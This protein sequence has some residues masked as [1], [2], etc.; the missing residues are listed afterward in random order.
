MQV[1]KLAWPSLTTNWVLIYCKI[2]RITLWAFDLRLG[3][4]VSRNFQPRR[5]SLRLV[6]PMRLSNYQA[7]GLYRVVGLSIVQIPSLTMYRLVN[8]SRAP[9]DL[10]LS[11]ARDH[12]E[13]L[14]TY[15]VHGSHEKLNNSL[16]I[17]LHPKILL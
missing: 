8:R 15:L 4:G 16:C 1:E 9:W 11:E 7:I 10:V 13:G 5:V 12:I 14:P 3:R 17:Y 6:T 2:S